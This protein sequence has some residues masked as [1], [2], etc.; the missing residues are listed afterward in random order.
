MRFKPIAYTNSATLAFRWRLRDSN[1]QSRE[2]PVLQTGSSNR[3]TIASIR[4]C[5]RDSDSFRNVDSV[6][7]YPYTNTPFL[8]YNIFLFFCQGTIYKLMVEREELHLILSR[9]LDVSGNVCKAPCGFYAAPI[10]LQITNYGI[11]GVQ[12]GGRTH[13][14]LFTA[15]HATATTIAP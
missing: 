7:C 13:T 2:A 3:S 14:D 10:S 8:Y 5:V 1:P 12:Y 11:S 6:A 15:S 4:R 9:P